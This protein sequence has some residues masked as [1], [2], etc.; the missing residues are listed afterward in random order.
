MAAAAYHKHGIVLVD[1]RDPDIGDWLGRALS[2][3]AQTKFGK[4]GTK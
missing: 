2:A 4:R 1:L 3:W